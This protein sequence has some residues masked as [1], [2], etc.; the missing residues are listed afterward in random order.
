MP[1]NRAALAREAWRLLFD[2]FMRSRPHRD[3]VLAR[4]KLTPNDSKALASLN[5]DGGKT[6]TALA[7]E[8]ATDPSN[9]T[10]V[11][12][13]LER[14]GLAR[15]RA[16]VGDR[17]KRLI[18]LTP[19]GAR[20]QRAIVEAFHEPP[21]ELVKLTAAELQALCAALAKTR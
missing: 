17:R 20:T 15:R 13:R 12:D 16:A 14:L 2:L 10:W 3:A 5:V 8:W 4:L 7:H 18:V 9:V 1:P 21:P 11:V 6:M 19:R